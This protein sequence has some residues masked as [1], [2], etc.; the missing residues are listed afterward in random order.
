MSNTIVQINFKFNLPAADYRA[1]AS[2]A[3][4]RIAGVTG[5]LWKIWIVNEAL[6]EAGGIY[7]FANEADAHA[8]VQ[9]PI[10]SSLRQQPFCSNFSAKF[11]GI[12]EEITAITR[13]PLPLMSL[14]SYIFKPALAV[15]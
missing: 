4:E 11:F 2:Q 7:L 13:G 10:I 8:Y 1:A 15:K 12:A 5:L 6:Q 14:S 9:G 3:A